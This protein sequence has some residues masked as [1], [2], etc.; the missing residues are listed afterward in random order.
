MIRFIV[1]T[2]GLSETSDL[3]LKAAVSSFQKVFDTEGLDVVV[4]HVEAWP[5]KSAEVADGM[6]SSLLIAIVLS[7]VIGPLGIAAGVGLTWYVFRKWS[8]S[9]AQL[10]REIQEQMPEPQFGAQL[11]NLQTM[12]DYSTENVDNQILQKNASPL[13][14]TGVD[15]QVLH[16][17]N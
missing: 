3:R 7:S 6:S 14:Q 10:G 4:S 8:A 9:R 17:N 12:Q 15:E 11:V 5:Y 2:Q 1:Y 13:L 16:L